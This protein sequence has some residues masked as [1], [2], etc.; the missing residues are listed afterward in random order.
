MKHARKDAVIDCIKYLLYRVGVSSGALDFQE[1]N[2]AGVR[3]FKDVDE[4]KTIFKCV[5]PTPC[6]PAEWGFTVQRKNILYCYIVFYLHCF[7]IFCRCSNRILGRNRN[8]FVHSCRQCHITARDRQ[9]KYQSSIHIDRRVLFRRQTIHIVTH[10]A[11]LSTRLSRRRLFCFRLSSF[12][13]FPFF[14]SD[15][16]C[17]SAIIFFSVVKNTKN[18]ILLWIRY[19]Y[20]VRFYIDDENSKLTDDIKTIFNLPNGNLC[21]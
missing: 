3:K 7:C 20:C 1:D 4:C 13:R 2:Y 12:P 17:W 18:R 21:F 6:I 8:Q 16:V 14:H 11:P 5:T 10:Q 19:V 9:S 15:L